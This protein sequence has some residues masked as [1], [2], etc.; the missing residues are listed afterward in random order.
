MAV[1]G[2]HHMGHHLDIDN[3][4]VGMPTLEISA[5]LGVG[6]TGTARDNRL[7]GAFKSTGQT[8]KEW[9]KG[10]KR[11][12]Y[13]AQVTT[14]KTQ[15]RNQRP[16]QV[17]ATQWMDRKCITQVST[18][19]GHW[20]GNLK[21]KVVSCKNGLFSQPTFKAP[22]TI[23]FYSQIK[24]GTDRMDQQ[25]AYFYRKPMMKWHL[26]VF[27]HLTLIALN[28]AHITYLE[29]NDIPKK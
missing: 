1:P 3:W 24:V 13:R 4:F 6:I 14:L 20:V 19:Q 9:A 12:A 26:K 17:L 22:T 21:R 5:S 15:L 29:T 2:L 23:P 28:N 18:Y 16:V 7:C 10:K 11:G 8:K 25:V 27:Y